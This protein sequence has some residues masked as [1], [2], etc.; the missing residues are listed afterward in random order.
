M[1]LVPILHCRCTRTHSPSSAAL[2]RARWCLDGTV[3]TI[4]RARQRVI[5]L[6]CSSF[7]FLFCVVLAFAYSAAHCGDGYVVG[8]EACDTSTFSHPGCVGCVIQT[9][10]TCTYNATTPIS[11]CAGIILCCERQVWIFVFFL[12]CQLIFFNL[13]LLSPPLSS[14][15]CVLIVLTL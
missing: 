5:A 4:T 10:Y 3:I 1:G 14:S 2:T 6:V 9:G 12:F 11:T 7:P 8:L 15:I 13:V